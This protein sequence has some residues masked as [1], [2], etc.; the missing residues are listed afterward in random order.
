MVQ[1]LK[2]TVNLTIYIKF[3]THKGHE[4]FK[5]NYTSLYITF[6]KVSF[7]PLVLMIIPDIVPSF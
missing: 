5:G 4:M 3:F 2:D 6:V 1:L 7:F